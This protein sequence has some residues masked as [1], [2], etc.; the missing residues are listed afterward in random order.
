MVNRTG[1][2]S[3]GGYVPRY[4]L[5]SET[6]AS[7]WGD[8]LPPG[9][10]AVANADEDSLT[11]A[12]EAAL[13][14]LLMRENR[15][16]DFRPTIDLVV[17]ASTTSPYL[18][19]QA[20]TVIA[21]VCDL[22]REVRTH[23]ITNSMRAG[24]QAIQTALDAVE[25]GSARQAL[26][27]AADM[28][29]AAP[30]SAGEAGFGDGSAALVLGEDRVIAE[31]VSSFSLA[32]EITDSWRR[33]GD[34]FARLW[35][36]RFVQTKGYLSV[37]P[38][39]I[40]AS[41]SKARLSPKD[42]ARIVGNGPDARSI[43]LAAKS[44]G[45]N[46]AT[47]A[48]HLFDTVGNTGAA[49]PLMVLARALETA[50]PGE[51]ILLFSYGGGADVLIFEVTPEIGNYRDGKK[52]GVG[53]YLGCSAPLKSYEQFIRFRELIV[54]EAPRRD[55]PVASAVQ[56]WRDRDIIYGLYGTQCTAC[57]AFQY[58]PQRICYKCQVLDQNE[59]VRFANRKSTLFTYTRDFLN[60]D[61]DP[62][63]VMSVINF[64]G[65]G[66]MYCMMTDRDPDKVA[67]GMPLE[68]TFRR[69]FEASG[70]RNYYWKCRPV[71]SSA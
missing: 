68:M 3:Y 11:L 23:D 16:S 45:L 13:D 50:Q 62:P 12:A 37:V 26:V 53:Y 60:A 47:V 66:R 40:K 28:R 25:A 1:I 65:G 46:P 19:K 4:R 5:S 32:D 27:T 51:R 35:E 52:R 6:L 30:R 21:Q 44:A 55:L 38:E 2:V 67:I 59:P 8:R 31:I 10:R 56:T 33:P 57:G 43:A 29:N 14:S 34:S 64:E 18:E 9:G 20:S 42:I 15:D 41:L 24:T 39:A 69:I 22:R 36:E 61:I 48:D 58:P 71:V 70:F 63:S 7:A 54:T 17:F 49:M